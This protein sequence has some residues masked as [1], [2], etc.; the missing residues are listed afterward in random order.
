M[1]RITTLTILIIQFIAVMAQPINRKALVQR[2][3]VINIKYDSL[4]SLTLGNGG[5][6]C[7]VDITG[8]QSFPEAYSKGIPLGTQ[9]QWGWDSF[10]DTAGYRF[11]ESLK[12][13]RLHN[14][15][16]TYA[17]QWHT[18]ERNKRAGDWFRQNVHR[19]QLGNIGFEILKK[20]GEPC[21]LADLKNVKQELDLWNGLIRSH[22]V[23]EGIPVDVMTAVHP[24]L[25]VIA[26][27][28]HSALLKTKR[29]KIRIRFP[30]PTGEFADAGVNR[31]NDDKHTSEIH[32]DKLQYSLEHQ[33]DNYRY[34]LHIAGTKISNINKDHPHDFS[35]TPT[36][37]KD[38]FEASFRFA[39]QNGKENLPLF[40][41]VKNSAA[42][43]WNAYWQRG[44]AVDFSGSTDPR[45]FEL[46][47]RIILSQYLMAVQCAGNMPP[48]ETGLTYNS[49]YGKPHLEMYWWHTVHFALWNRIDLM[50][51][52]LQ[53][54]AT[55]AGKA[56]AI[57]ARQ[58]YEGIRWQKMTDPQG[59]ESPSSVGAFLLWQQPHYIYMTELV[60]RHYHN[61][62]TLD[63][64]K[65]LVFATADFMASYAAYDSAAKRYVLGK[66]V[67]PAQERF[68]PEE[69]FNP[70][71]ELAYWRWGLTTAQLWRERL[72]LPRKA[73]W[74]VVLKGLSALPQQDSVY[75]A[76][77][78]APDSYTNAPFMTDHPA[79][80]GALGMLPASSFLD[81]AVMHRTF[82]KIWDIWNW[83]ETWGWDFPLTS[84]TAT[85][86]GLRQKAIDALFI[87]VQ[88]NTWLPNGHNYQDERLRL[89]L[90][91]NGGLL[92]AVA[93]MC[94]GY[95]GCSRTNPGIPDDGKW[96]VKWEGLQ[97]MP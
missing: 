89:Y 27:S 10:T 42:V 5:F 28:V 49:W 96:K 6:A 68:K 29:L 14:R 93:L 92:T 55:V 65:D 41:M 30:Y 47:R 16:I 34:Y 17:V 31:G 73:A 71:F 91:G 61:R 26:V 74:D 46:E 22:F 94:A 59:N 23:V 39:E 12:A 25:D 82:N 84:M 8:L 53:W 85:R 80:L 9:S 54:Y 86:L 63:K 43:Y 56:K 72:G 33:L 87:P 32:A 48:Q 19:L 21:T 36:T 78:S 1:K 88:T 3:N 62:A 20:N 76:A 64:Y 18:P 45:A 7:T 4:S 66:G 60:Y 24:E 37:E 75:L 44:G 51:K 40:E 52:S 67:I 79:V 70:T 83:K 97:Q 50:E 15:D 13:Y 2:H 90:P 69:T 57:A 81:T 35:I 38:T 58:G 77:E 11:E 95:D